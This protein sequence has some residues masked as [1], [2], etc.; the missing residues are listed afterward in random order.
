M[1]RSN[2]LCIAALI[3]MTTLPAL[4]Y[5]Q[6]PRL[7][8]AKAIQIATRFSKAIGQS[9]T[10]A[11]NTVTYPAPQFYSGE[12]QPYWQPR[13]RIVFEGQA[14]FE[15]IDATGAIA[16]YS[17]DALQ[18]QLV[19]NPPTRQPLAASVA[20]RIATAALHVAGAVPELA[21][22]PSST[23]ARITPGSTDG[24]EWQ[25]VWQRRDP[26][27]G[28]VYPNQQLS[29]FLQ[30]ETGAIEMFGLYC[31]SPSPH[32][33]AFTIPRSQATATAQSLLQSIG[34]QNPS[35]V[36]VQRRIVQPNTFW[37]P[38]GS[39]TSQFN[40]AGL[41][42]WWCTFKDLKQVYDVW[43]DAAAGMVAGGEKYSIRPRAH[44]SKPPLKNSEKVR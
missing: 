2:R 38:G 12:Q 1:F 21:T 8:Q 36:A 22:N 42:V 28:I 16:Y 30:G 40:V 6:A 20:V 10:G 39:G 41:A 34:V 29:V 19:K 31:P 18:A 17:N 27:S 32:A 24:D 43:V 25:V 15:V 9:M 13:W 7:T 35:L 3:L 44:E 5:A 4:A 33:V 37:Q 14:E 11:P 23:L 26:T